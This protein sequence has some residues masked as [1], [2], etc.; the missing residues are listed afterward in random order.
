[1]LIKKISPGEENNTHT[2]IF[3]RGGRKWSKFLE[4]ISFEILR[5]AKLQKLILQGLIIRGPLIDMNW[6]EERKHNSRQSSIFKLKSRGSCEPNSWDFWKLKRQKIW[7]LWRLNPDACGD[8]SPQRFEDSNSEITRGSN[9]E[10]M[11]GHVLLQPNLKSLEHN[12]LAI[13]TARFSSWNKLY[14]DNDWDVCIF[15]VAVGWGD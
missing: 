6:P 14:D 4:S 15:C 11:L 12:E 8:S 2:F 7:D 13:L 10:V 3:T 9:R 1:M 5:S